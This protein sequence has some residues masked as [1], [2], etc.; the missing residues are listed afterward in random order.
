MTAIYS[1]GHSNKPIGEFIELLESAGVKTLV[2]VRTRPQSRF[3][4]QFNRGR[5]QPELE[6]AGIKYEWRGNNLGG[7]GLNEDYEGTIEEL[8]ERAAAGEMIAVCC[9]EKDIKNCHR[10]S[11]LTPS[12]HDRNVDVVHI[13]WTGELQEDPAGD[14]PVES[15]SLF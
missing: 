7:L 1:V 11:K 13:L 14:A 6:H 4:P 10:K 8:S 12:F 2:D 3:C 9:S 15:E 5:M